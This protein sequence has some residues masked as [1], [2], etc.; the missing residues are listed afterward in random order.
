MIG[1]D[2]EASRTKIYCKTLSFGHGCG[3][4]LF[5]DQFQS[6]METPWDC[7]TQHKEILGQHVGIHGQRMDGHEYRINI[8]IASCLIDF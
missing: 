1:S 6:C 7:R 5:M 2:R 3:Y 8:T 4:D